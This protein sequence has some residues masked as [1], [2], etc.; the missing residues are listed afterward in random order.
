[1]T[2]P[3]PTELPTNPADLAELG[4]DDA[5]W[6]AWAAANPELA[7][8]VAIARKVRLLLSAMQESQIMVPEGFEDRLMDRIRQDR[9]LLDLIDLGL[10]GIGRTILELLAALFNILPQLAPQPNG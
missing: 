9:T 7:N 1:M 8:E 10:S 5:T 2:L 3:D 4:F 6:D